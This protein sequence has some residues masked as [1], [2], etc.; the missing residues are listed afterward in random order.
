MEWEWSIW[1]REYSEIPGRSSCH[2]TQNGIPGLPTNIR[3][4]SGRKSIFNVVPGIAFAWILLSYFEINQYK[5][6]ILIYF[7]QS[8]RGP[9]LNNCEDLWNCKISEQKS[10][11]IPPKFYADISKQC[12]ESCQWQFSISGLTREIEVTDR[13]RPSSA[14]Y[15]TV[16]LCSCVENS[17]FSKER[18]SSEKCVIQQDGLTV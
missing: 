13:F 1:I 12:L 9:V 7:R 3:Y 11:D 17:S 5:M 18:K 2:R 15:P 16:L 4:F 10:K 14:A 6:W 8:F